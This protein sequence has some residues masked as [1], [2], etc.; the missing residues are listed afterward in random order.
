MDGACERVLD[1][2]GGGSPAAVFVGDI[3]FHSSRGVDFK[4][5]RVNGGAETCIIGTGVYV[6]GIV[7]RVV[8]GI[9]L[10]LK[11]MSRGA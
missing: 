9:G 2:T 4:L 1:V 7:S 11:V 6:V 3:V 8:C 10:A 5:G